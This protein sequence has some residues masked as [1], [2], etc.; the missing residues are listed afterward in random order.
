MLQD[1]R[2]IHRLYLLCGIPL[3]YRA[4][5]FETDVISGCTD[6]RMANRRELIQAIRILKGEDMD[7]EERKEQTI[8]RELAFARLPQLLPFDSLNEHEPIGFGT[9][10][11]EHFKSSATACELPSRPVLTTAPF[12]TRIS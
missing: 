2:S 6:I 8:V 4:E 1:I 3:E 12:L 9:T 5:I 10:G 11:R 7:E